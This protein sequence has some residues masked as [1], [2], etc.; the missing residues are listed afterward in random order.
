MS[1]ENRKRNSRKNPAVISFL[2][3]VF[4]FL[5]Q[6]LSFLEVEVEQDY[7]YQGDPV[8]RNGT[9]ESF[10]GQFDQRLLLFCHA[11]YNMPFLS[12]IR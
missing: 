9:P 6:T 11:E 8:F 12:G 2:H 10:F 5:A 3:V 4:A 7:H 1:A